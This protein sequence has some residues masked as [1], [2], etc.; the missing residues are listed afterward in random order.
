MKKITSFIVLLCVPFISA[1][2]QKPNKPI[3]QCSVDLPYGV[4]AYN[5]PNSIV[6]CLDGF[7]LQH[8]NVAKISPWAAWTL[9]PQESIGCIPRT[10]AFVADGSIPKGQRAEVSDY[11]KSGYD[12]GHMVPDG[13]LSYNQ[14]VEYESFLM[15]NMSPQ[16]PNLN[17][18]AWKLLETHTR[19]WAFE[20]KHN[21][22]V[23]SGNIYSKDSKTIGENKVVVPDYI[24]KII[25]DNSTGEVLSFAFPQV[26]K[27]DTDLNTKLVSVE[28]I[29]KATSIVFPLPASYDKKQ[30]AKSIWPVDLNKVA[31]AKKETCKKK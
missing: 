7:A 30:V 15:S 10:D 29:E 8:D 20:R 22:T 13:D 25:I 5:N 11:A 1:W 27:Q 21:L 4:P 3:N 14:Q 28:W 24:Y 6:R 18:G 2:D 23:Y 19:A 16:L 9:T 17:R 31:T 12:K 26:P